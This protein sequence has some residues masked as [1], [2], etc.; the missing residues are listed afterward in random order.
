MLLITIMTIVFA[1][2]AAFGG[3]PGKPQIGD[4]VSFET[5]PIDLGNWGR[6]PHFLDGFGGEVLA[7]IDEPVRIERVLLLV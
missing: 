1:E 4:S 7:G 5:A 3:V 2:N 6:C